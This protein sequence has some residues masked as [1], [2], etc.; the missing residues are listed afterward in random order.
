MR[1]FTLATLTHPDPQIRISDLS[2]AQRR[3][4]EIIKLEV[5]SLR[6]SSITLKCGIII[7][8]ATGSGKSQLLVTI[9]SH[10]K[11]WREHLN[12]SKLYSWMTRDRNIRYE[13]TKVSI[14]SAI[15]ANAIKNDGVAVIDDID[16]GPNVTREGIIN[17]ITYILNKGINNELEYFIVM[18]MNTETYRFLMRD[19]L[20]RSKI[21]QHFHVIQLVWS[22][23]ELIKAVKRRLGILEWTIDSNVLKLIAQVAKTPRSASIMAGKVKEKDERKFIVEYAKRGLY[24]A[25]EYYIK[26]LVQPGG[27]LA[28]SRSKEGEVR[29]PKW[30]RFWKEILGTPEEYCGLLQKLIQGY[31]RSA[32]ELAK[33][34]PIVNK[35]FSRN[36]HWVLTSAVKWHILIK[37]PQGYRFNDELLSAAAEFYVRSDETAKSM[38]DALASTLKLSQ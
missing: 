32:S 30:M 36:T 15:R 28:R 5:E 4:Y 17:F 10:D 20:F 1:K 26:K 3:A 31:V 27:P 34:A 7:L 14:E 24:R 18:T 23:E 19:E 11:L 6:E 25:Y 12:G 2:D 37:E 35:Y 8:G 29:E 16:L 21:S 38:L 33:I 13:K 22:N 9:N